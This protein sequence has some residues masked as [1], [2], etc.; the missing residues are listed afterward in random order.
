MAYVS[1]AY[2]LL[3]GTIKDNVCFG[4]PYDEEKFMKASLLVQT[5]FLWRS[6]QTLV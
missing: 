5:L 3:T 4:L 2:W 1:Q 6:G